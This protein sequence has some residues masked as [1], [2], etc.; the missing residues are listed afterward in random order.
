MA[1]PGLD[2][3][4]ITAF[5]SHS[6][7]SP[8]LSLAILFFFF[9]FFII[10]V[11]LEQFCQTRHTICWKKQIQDA[12]ERLGF[13][14]KLCLFISFVFIEQQ[15]GRKAHNIINSQ[16]SGAPYKHIYQTIK[17]TKNDQFLGQK[18]G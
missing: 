16:K 18:E 5:V 7:P 4:V 14:A 3:S 12:S 11:Q 6:P 17:Q 2:A 13:A 15:I 1:L 10:V 8:I 9:F